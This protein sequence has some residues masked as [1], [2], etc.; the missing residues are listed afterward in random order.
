LLC[1]ISTLG[2]RPTPAQAPGQRT[3]HGSDDKPQPMLQLN[4]LRYV[5]APVLSPD[6]RL[7]L[8]PGGNGVVS[9]W[10]VASGRLIRLLVGHT[11]SVSAAAFSPDGSRAVTASHDTSVRLWEVATGKQLKIWEPATFEGTVSFSHDGKSILVGPFNSPAYVVDPEPPSSVLA[12]LLSGLF[13]TRRFRV[14]SRG[15]ARYTPDGR[16]VLTGEPA[17]LLDAVTGKVVRSFQGKRMDYSRDGTYVLT[18]SAQGIHVW[19]TATG[20]QSR[21]LGMP[22][23]MEPQEYELVKAL[24]S[25]NNQ[26]VLTVHQYSASP[27]P[28]PDIVRLWNVANG[29]VVK[30]YNASFRL[31]SFGSDATT[32]LVSKGSEVALVDVESG[33]RAQA[34]GGWRDSI[35]MIVSSDDGRYVVTQSNNGVRLWDLQ[36]GGQVSASDGAEELVRKIVSHLYPRRT[37]FPDTEAGRAQYLMAREKAAEMEEARVE[38]GHSVPPFGGADFSPD[39]RHV[40]VGS[41]HQSAPRSV[42]LRSARLLETATKK[43]VRRFDGHLDSVWAVAFLRNTNFVLSGSSDST[44]RI[45][46]ASTGREVCKL[47]SL[48]DGHWL[49][50]DP[51]GHFDT[52]NIEELNFLNWVMPDDPTTPLPLEIF[53]R[54][55]YEPR[56]LARLLVGGQ[57]K[58][59]R[60]LGELNRFQPV[61]KIEKVEQAAGAV[62]TVSVTVEVGRASDEF[63]RDGKKVMRETGVYDLRLFRDGQL[64]GVSTPRDKLAQR[65]GDGTRP[66]SETGASGKLADTPEDRAWREA[67][68][69]FKLQTEDI[70]ILSPGRLQYTFRNIKLPRDGRRE[71]VFTAYA[72]NSDRVKSATTAPLKFT[73]PSAVADAPKKGRAFLVSIG[74]NASENPAYDLRFA[75]NDARKMQEVIGKRLKADSSR[76]SEVILIPLISDY[77]EGGKGEENRAQKAIIKGVFSL[78]SGDEREVPPDVIA[79]IP[80]RAQIKAVDPED[81]LI[82]TYAGHGYADQAGIFYLLPYDIGA[83]TTQLTA[84]ALGKTISSDELSLWMQEIT[85]AEMIMIIDACH[86]AAAVQGNGF[87]PGPMGSRGLGQLAYDKDMKILSA[88]QADNVALE[89]GSLE[90]G[91]LSYALLQD[92]II[93]SLADADQDKQLLAAEWLS[94]A[95][96]RVPELYREAREGKRSDFRDG[97]RLNDGGSRADIVGADGNQKRSSNLQQP[98]LFD[99]KRRGTKNALFILP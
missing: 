66:A 41:D 94:Y 69:I 26:S 96:R 44:T 55:Y 85:A 98:S 99:F 87:K 70:K 27:T 28:V 73:I 56:L 33:A 15:F 95:A 24:I 5:G 82:I 38:W 80:N 58:P 42:A 10:G 77:G 30:R 36:S 21:L 61:V 81:T 57:L 9:L 31:L 40:L 71:V 6:G 22:P 29:Q 32:A 34:F 12:E 90:Q 63:S 16:H 52:D 37:N 79:Q 23:G 74:V 2:E 19:E 59:V 72:F 45:W 50:A 49:V 20:R 83:N 13:S 92:G 67:N 7:L 65:M 14:N 75:A 93:T 91:L 60:P 53:M 89:L 64:V 39:G 76:Y 97:R 86:S 47:I 35:Q 62:G 43:E 1:V 48:K 68:D 54:D 46:D 84:G 8:I 18:A 88:T 4:T 51:D 25:P 17:V 11:D 3:E 78:L